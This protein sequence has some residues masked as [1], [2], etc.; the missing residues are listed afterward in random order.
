[1][2]DDV[3]DLNEEV[4]D[5]PEEGAPAFSEEALALDFAQRH[6]DDL[7]YVAQ[8]GKWYRWDGTR[9]REDKTR[10]VFDLS[11]AL[12][13]E[14]AARTNKSGHGKAIASAKTRAAVVSLASEDRRLAATV[15]QWDAD[16]WLLNTPGGIVDLRTGHVRGAT[17]DDYMTMITAV[18]PSGDCPLWHA[19]LNTVTDNDADLKKFLQVASGYSLTGSTREQ[20]LLFL[21]GKGQNGKTVFIKAVS[22]ALGD[23][24]TAAPMEM[25]VDLIHDRHPTDLAGLRGAR[26]VTCAETEQGRRWAESK[27]KQLTGDDVI[28]ARFMRQDFFTYEPQFLLM[29]YGNNK[30]GLKSVDD[31]I[32]RR[33][34][35]T[36]FAV[37]ISEAER[38]KELQEKL[39]AEWPGILAWMIEGCLVWQRGG[40]SR[41]KRSK[42]PRRITSPPRTPSVGGSTSAAC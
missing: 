17:P 22:G 16:P 29:V 23:Y 7:R 34:K 3:T 32:R 2:E 10:K 12:C 1:M 8:W 26:L 15:E 14:A 24:H 6:A 4:T 38:D 27:I 25:L 42:P 35:L 33:I 36:P 5:L 31:A 39:K 11:R 18:A 28:R 40:W 21:Y 13:R 41:Q 30:P 20:I 19:F 37:K 9:W